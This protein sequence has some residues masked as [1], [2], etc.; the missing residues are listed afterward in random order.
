[1]LLGLWSRLLAHGTGRW[2]ALAG[3]VGVVCGVVGFIFNLAVNLGLAYGVGWAIGYTPQLHG[4]QVGTMPSVSLRPWLALPVLALG[5][6][7]AGWIA[8]RFDR[9]AAGGGSEHAVEAFHKGR[10]AISLRLTLSK[11]AASTAT[12]GSGGS[13]GREGPISL[14]GAGFGSFVAE[15]LG[16]AVRDRRTLL[17]A[18]IAGGMAAVFHAPFAAALFAVEVLYRGPDLE[19][20]ALVPAAI[21][22]VVGFLVAGVCE[23]LWHTAIGIT[24]PMTGSLLKI[25]SG[26][27]F[28]TGDWLQLIGYLAVAVACAAGSYLFIVLSNAIHS[29]SE[30]ACQPLWL[31]TAIG[32]AATGAIAVGLWYALTAL[33]GGPDPRIGFVV[34]GPGYGILQRTLESMPGI[35]LALALTM[36]A[37][38]K[39][40]STACTVGT[41]GSGGLFAP[42]LVIGGCL[43]GAVASALHGLPIAPP[44]SAGVLVGMAAFLAASHRTPMAAIFMSCEI[45]GSYA[46]LIPSLWTCGIAFLLLGRNTLVTSQTWSQAQSDAHGEGRAHDPFSEGRV[47]DVL[48]SEPAAR[49]L[50]MSA[51]LADCRA[52]LVGTGQT[53]IPVLDADGKLLGVVTIDDLRQFLDDHDADSLILV[54]DLLAGRAVALLPDDQLS[55]ALRRFA[56]HPLDDLPVVDAQGRYLGLLRRESLFRWYHNRMERVAADLRADGADLSD[57]SWRHTTAL[58]PSGAHDATR[59][60]TGAQPAGEADR[61]ASSG[62]PGVARPDQGW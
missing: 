28:A 37:V 11:L 6:A 38:A 47:G 40:L 17:V 2:L 58:D 23:G 53:T 46:L 36:V 16:L 44:L 54:A 4:P 59:L 14:V 24:A 32:G 45:G 35:P 49:T 51:N 5:G 25:P 39:M 33:A 48:A 60:P 3:L 8:M 22:A 41:G 27:E 42:S 21:S 9:R 56:E 12:L 50:L 26:A 18:G 43:G 55:R 1:M 29:F 34:L 7:L 19:G 62:H 31:R 20:D 57:D 52:V 13:A 15:R 30:R 61:L 10:G